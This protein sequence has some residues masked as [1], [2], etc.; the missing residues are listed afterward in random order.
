MSLTMWMIH[1]TRN[2][3]KYNSKAPHSRGIQK[4]VLSVLVRPIEME[5]IATKMR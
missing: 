4:P 3:A 1:L 5:M 2:N